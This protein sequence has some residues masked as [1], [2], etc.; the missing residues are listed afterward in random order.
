MT[1]IFTFRIMSFEY[2]IQYQFLSFSDHGTCLHTVIDF[3]GVER[4]MIVLGRYREIAN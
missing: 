4:R 3:L 1:I 2:Q